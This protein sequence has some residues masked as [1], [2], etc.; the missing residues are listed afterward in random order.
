VKPPLPGKPEFAVVDG[1]PGEEFDSISSSLTFSPDSRNVAYLARNGSEQFAVINGLR[2]EPYDLVQAPTFS[3][4]SARFA[5][6]AP[7][8]VLCLRV[9]G[10]R[11]PVWEGALWA[12]SLIGAVLVEVISEEKQGAIITAWSFAYL[13]A[14]IVL[15]AVLIRSHPGVRR[16]VSWM[17]ASAIL[18]VV[19]LNIHDLARWMGWI[20]YDS[21]TLAHF[22]IPLVLFAVGATLIERH[23]RAVAATE[24]TNVELEKEVA[25]KAREIEAG[26]ARVQ[27]AAG[28]VGDH[29]VEPAV[30]VEVLRARA[31]EP[32]AADQVLL[33]EPAGGDQPVQ[34][35]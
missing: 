7:M 31:H 19:L 13:G 27:E 20:D 4:N 29:E 18:L 5:Y 25:A 16:W 15:L 26:C 17:F 34:H 14:L 12:F 10:K 6:A 28:G 11:W 35:V 33:A 2:G 23:F 24:R 8:L 32:L 22:H 21:L 1:I 9:A 3:P 30:A